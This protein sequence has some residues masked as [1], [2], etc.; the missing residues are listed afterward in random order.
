MQT[1]SSGQRRGHVIA[2]H[3]MSYPDPLR[4]HAG[5]MVTLDGREDPWDG[6]P[7]WTYLWCI[8]QQG[9]GGWVPADLIARDSGSGTGAARSDYDT[10]ELS[11]NAGED[12]TVE[13]AAYGW[14]WCTNDQSVSGWVPASKVEVSDAA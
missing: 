5:E 4:V 13:R 1:K 12:V 11:V 7:E 2:D 8:S 10:R 9:K 6:H 14:L 3:Q